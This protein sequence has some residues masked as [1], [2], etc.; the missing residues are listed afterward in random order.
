MV[1]KFK[2]LIVWQKSMDLVEEIYKL[3][4]KLP[5]EELY[6]L[7]DQIRRASVSIPSNIAEGNNRS[8][9]KDFIKFLY[10]SKGSNAELETQLLIAL[11]LKYFTETDAEKALVLCGE[12]EKMLNALIRN[13]ASKLELSDKN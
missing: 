7:S 13:L 8:S 6:S 3:T 1:K 10:I 5:R 2:D 9:T 11:R 12:I 4:K